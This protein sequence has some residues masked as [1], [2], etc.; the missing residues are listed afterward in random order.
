MGNQEP[1]QGSSAPALWQKRRVLAEDP[2]RSFEM[3][4]VLGVL[5][6]PGHEGSCFSGLSFLLY[7]MV[8]IKTSPPCSTS[9]A[10]QQVRGSLLK[11]SQK[12]ELSSFTH[13]GGGWHPM[14]GGI[15]I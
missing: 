13:R 4:P 5:W 7:K 2:R 12:K 14:R 8:L 1:N 3:R 15:T 10:S 11:G 9:F 6:A